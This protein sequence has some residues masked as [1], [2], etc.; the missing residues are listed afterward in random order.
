MV[1]VTIRYSRVSNRPLCIC[2]H[3]GVDLTDNNW[4]ETKRRYSNYSCAS[5]SNRIAREQR[6]ANV[7]HARKL[8][9]ARW[10]TLTPERRDRKRETDRERRLRLAFGMD[11]MDYE[12]RLA[13]QEYMCAI[14]ESDSPGETE[15]HFYVDHCHTTGTVRGLLCNSCNLMLG[16]AKDNIRILQRAITYL[17]AKK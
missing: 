17:E 1:S 12:T 14:C 7:E 5:C 6:A 11:I 10:A 16:K 13:G 9:R 8:D 2:I 15:T 4:N 3:C